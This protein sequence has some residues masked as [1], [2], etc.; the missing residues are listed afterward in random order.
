MLQKFAQ[1]ARKSNGK[2]T[3]ADFSNYLGQPVSDKVME[4][5]NLY[6]IVS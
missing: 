5:F 6:D 3:L 1:F 4:L 2:M